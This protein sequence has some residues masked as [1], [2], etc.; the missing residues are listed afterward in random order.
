MEARSAHGRDA[1]RADRG[2]TE[3]LCLS[4]VRVGAAVHEIGV[5][6]LPSIQGLLAISEGQTAVAVSD[7]TTAIAEN[8]YQ[9]AGRFDDAVRQ[10]AR[11]GP[12]SSAAGPCTNRCPRR[13]KRP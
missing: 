9:T 13:P 4:I 6:R 12:A 2:G 10:R 11:A 7:L 3:R 1:G 5:V 8:D